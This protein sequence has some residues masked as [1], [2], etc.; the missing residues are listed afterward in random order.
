VN[1]LLGLSEGV[2]LL[3]A[4]CIG[5]VIVAVQRWTRGGR[6]LTRSMEQA[7]VLLCLAGAL[8]MLIVGD[9]L[10]RAFG[11]AGAAAIVRFR[12]PVDDPRDITVLFLLMALGMAA[13]LGLVAVA[14][15]GALLVCGCLFLAA[16]GRRAAAIDEVALVAQGRQFPATHV[17]RV[18]AAHE[19]SV[20]P[21]KF[22]H[23]DHAAV[24][25]R[26]RLGREPR[27]TR[28][29]RNS[30]VAATSASPRY[31]GKRRRKDCSHARHS[32]CGA[33]AP[34][35]DARGAQDA[36][37]ERIRP[38]RDGAS[39]G[40]IIRKSN[41]PA[42]ARRFR[43]ASRVR[44]ASPAPPSSARLATP[45]M[46][47]AA[48]SASPARLGRTFEFQLEGELQRSEPWR[49]VFVNYRGCAARRSRPDDSR[50][51][52]G[53]E[54]TTG[55]GNLEFIY[56]SIVSTRL[57]PGRDSGTMLHGRM[58]GAE[59]ATKSDFRARRRQC[60]SEARQPGVRRSDDCRPHHVEPFRRSKSTL[61][62]LQVGVAYT[63][64]SFRKGSPRCG[65]QPAGVSFFDSDLWVEGSRRRSGLQLR[66]RPGPFSVASEY[67]RVSDDRLGQSREATNLP[68]FLAR[69]WY[70]SGTW[71]VAGAA[72]A[73]SVAQTASIHS[74]RAASGRF[75]SRCGAST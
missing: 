37:N 22:R 2:R 33:G 27:S 35:R 32:I 21:L 72:R 13:G 10:P 53:L 16:L 50:F 36:P 26:A 23:G 14:A 51:P 17:S 38:M 19:I 12:T 66:W 40:T 68:P 62:D 39:D 8:M 61:A 47:A 29:A 15:I 49:D 48:A 41:G 60:A 24:R 1:A 57:A 55:A 9:S 58:A 3:A 70:L 30:L 45:L 71:V 11:I 64:S 46:S 52:F 74:F 34:R 31:R 25:Y 63:R 42:V 44:A 28:S 5:I 7:H 75:R 6:P 65:A 73:A 69:G 59:S 18:F 43:R 67:I 56:R 54:E 20:E 4:I